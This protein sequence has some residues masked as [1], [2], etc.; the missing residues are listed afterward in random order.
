MPNG[1]LGVLGGATV[2]A[3]ISTEDKGFLCPALRYHAKSGS[4]TY[5]L[6]RP[7]YRSDVHVGDVVV[8]VVAQDD[9]GDMAVRAGRRTH[10]KLYSSGRVTMTDR[11]RDEP[12][13]YDSP[14]H[15]TSLYSL[16]RARPVP[17]TASQAPAECSV[18]HDKDTPAFHSHETFNSRS[19]LADFSDADCSHSQVALETNS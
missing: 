1:R 10:Q 9:V 8:V 11:C 13:S 18:P 14:W 5:T 3:S 4:T 16:R 2:A 15:S 17:A 6:E 12:V 19:H 7:P